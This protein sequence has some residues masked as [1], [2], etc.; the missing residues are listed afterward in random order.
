MRTEG[1]TLECF[2]DL[3]ARIGLDNFEQRAALAQVLGVGD[4]TVR[5][6]AVG[7][8]QPVGM[9]AV[10]LRYY[11]D[12]LGYKVSEIVHLPV[13]FR[14]ASQ[15][16]AFRVFTL[17]EM[18][19]LTGFEEYPDQV[20][21]VLRGTRGISAERKAQFVELVEAY[22][23]ELEAKMLR[24]PKLVTLKPI[25]TGSETRAVPSSPTKAV[26]VP[27]RALPVPSSEVDGAERRTQKV[28]KNLVEGLNE[29][30]RYYTNPD[31][32]E[33]VR[34]QLREA[35]GQKEIFDLKNRLSQLCGSRAF[36]NQQQQ[37]ATA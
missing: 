11:L 25:S 29:L 36:S 22:H 14:E 37:G 15:M 20:L 19:K 16:L 30:A 26:T 10:S 18:A 23:G 24:L 35:V 33:A 17:E 4:S 9:S 1:N 27:L 2:S 7:S 5:R 3:I 8:F 12:F 13:L 21:A 31:V 6:W 34:D 28:F 32:P